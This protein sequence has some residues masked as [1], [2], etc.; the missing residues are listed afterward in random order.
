MAPANNVVDLVIREVLP[1][2]RASAD[3]MVAEAQARAEAIIVAAQAEAQRKVGEY[4]AALPPLPEL[5]LLEPIEF[6]GFDP[7]DWIK[8]QAASRAWRTLVQGAVSAVVIA[9]VTALVQSI[10]DPGFDFTSAA[11]WKIALGLG[12]GAIGTAVASL[13]QNKLGIKPPR[14]P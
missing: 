3:A 9:F 2:L 13:V 4:I 8:R 12:L 5:E 7:V 11:D 1:Q 6:E 10:A 14:V